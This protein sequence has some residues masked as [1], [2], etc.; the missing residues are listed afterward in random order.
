MSY[1]HDQL[2]S[3]IDRVYTTVESPDRWPQV[4]GEIAERAGV[5]RA[6][7][8]TPFHGMDE[9]GF[10]YSHNLSDEELAGYIDYYHQIDV[11]NLKAFDRGIPTGVV[12]NCDRL[13]P[14]AELQE[15]EYYNNYL[16]YIDIQ[17]ALGAMFQGG[18]GGFPRTHMS[19]YRPIGS[20]HFGAE[21]E[22]LI[23]ELIPHVNR[24]LDLGFRFASLR[25]R[26]RSKL[27][28]LNRL[29]FAVA[30]LN[31][32]GTIGFMNQR[33]EQILTAA[34]GLAI[35]HTC[36]V[37]EHHDDNE[38]FW[39]LVRNTIGMQSKGERPAGGSVGISRPSG[40]RNYAVTVAPG[41]GMP[42]LAGVPM[43]WALIFIADP[44]L[45]PE[46]P[47]ER[48][49]RIHGLTSAEAQLAVGL[50]TGKTLSEYADST[51]LSMHTVRSTLK[52]VFAKTDTRRQAELV[53][54]L[55]TTTTA[56]FGVSEQN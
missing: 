32:D 15:T 6:L 44:E 22:H 18:T 12:I 31:Q 53:R 50:A 23:Q 9:G 8:F 2:L 52:Q 28:A 30:A 42:E 49:S 55:L 41:A 19:V 40:R 34:D 17:G 43:A 48:I 20:E 26:A 36:I 47:A 29:D 33:A 21:P 16:K 39:R 11:W 13:V 1:S 25:S 24:A 38:A 56:E 46:L 54:L 3:L 10:F 5:P 45:N 37:A 14:P 4:V 27:E 7:V 51:A 35:R